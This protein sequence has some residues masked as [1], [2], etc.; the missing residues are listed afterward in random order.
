MHPL[1]FYN[2]K[3]GILGSVGLYTSL[4]IICFT[5]C[6]YM[7]CSNAG[8]RSA[9]FCATDQTVFQYTRMLREMGMPLAP[10]FG[11]SCR[12][13]KVSSLADDMEYCEKVYQ[14]TL[15]L[16]GLPEDHLDKALGNKTS[17]DPVYGGE[18][19]RT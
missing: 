10:Y 1:G 18:G 5:A 19:D 17:S 6:N 15:E 2:V 13:A 3:R 8:A 12:P 4:V 9:L 11:S 14:K 16:V 7:E